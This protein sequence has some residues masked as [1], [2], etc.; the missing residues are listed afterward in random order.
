VIHAVGPVYQR[1]EQDAELLASAYRNS[2][3]LAA[4]HGLKTIAFQ[5]SAPAST[6]PD[7]PGCA[8]SAQAVK[9]YLAQHA[10]IELVRSYCDAVALKAYER[11]ARELLTM[12]IWRWQSSK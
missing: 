11:V 10:E 6:V 4:R 7:R 1:R 12:I 5:R 3:D 8:G 9:R 2:L